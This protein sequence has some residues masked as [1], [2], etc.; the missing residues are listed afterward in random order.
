METLN[1]SIIGSMSSTMAL[2]SEKLVTLYVFS[3][4]GNKDHHITLAFSADGT[5]WMQSQKD[6][7]GEGIMTVSHIGTHVRAV[8]VESDS[9][10]D[11]LSLVNI[12]II[13][14]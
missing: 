14:R 8:V 3:E 11:G 1:S 9:G 5:N 2:T 6:I 12:N 4:S 7:K 10:G 13:A